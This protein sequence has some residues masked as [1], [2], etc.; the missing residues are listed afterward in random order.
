MALPSAG[1]FRAAGSSRASNEVGGDYYDVHQLSPD[2]W[3]AVLADVS[4]K[5]VSSALLAS[6]LQGTFL[7][8]SGDPSHIEPRM[9]RLNEFL[10]ERTKGEKYATVF[11]CVLNRAGRFSY[12]NAAQCNPF[13]VNKTGDLRILESTSMPVGMFAGAPFQMLE[14]TLKPGDKI[15][16]YTDGVTEA[17]GAGG[18]FFGSDRLKQVIREN[19]AQSATGLHAALIGAVEKFIGSGESPEEAVRDDI[20]ALVI[21]YAG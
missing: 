4:G 6:L 15:V 16:I 21:E 1:W 3:V 11:Y 19:A 7:M 13:L 17:V 12:T 10:L 14:E 5:G 18:V 8:A 20:T 9:A 2:V